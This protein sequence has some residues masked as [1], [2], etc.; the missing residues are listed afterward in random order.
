MHARLVLDPSS[1]LKRPAILPTGTTCQRATINFTQSSER[2]RRMPIDTCEISGTYSSPSA[3]QQ[4]GQ[5]WQSM[6]TIGAVIFADT[7][8]QKHNAPSDLE[9]Q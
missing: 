2:R 5:H 3:R 8:A 1:I 7:D 6:M 9:R 4:I